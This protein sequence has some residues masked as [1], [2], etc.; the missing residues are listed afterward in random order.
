MA[1][2][3]QHRREESKVSMENVSEATSKKYSNVTIRMVS[4]VEN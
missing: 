3:G 4:G 2:E 1:M